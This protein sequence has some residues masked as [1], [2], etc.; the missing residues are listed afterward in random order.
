MKKCLHCSMSGWT[1][2]NFAMQEA[3]GFGEVGNP[4]HV[5]SYKWKQWIQVNLDLIS[6]H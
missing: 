1:N 4:Y 3:L 2:I 6:F 5:Q